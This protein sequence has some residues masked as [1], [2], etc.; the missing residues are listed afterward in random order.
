MGDS[1]DL[2]ITLCY[3]LGAL[4][5][6]L[7]A[8]TT[9][10]SLSKDGNVAF[11]TEEPLSKKKSSYLFKR[12]E[13]KSSTEKRTPDV[14][15]FVRGTA[16]SEAVSILG[17]EDKP[18]IGRNNES[19]QKTP[20]TPLIDLGYPFSLSQLVMNLIDCGLGLFRPD[21]SYPSLAVAINDMQ[22]LLQ[23]PSR[24][25]WNHYTTPHNHN[26][27]TNDVKLYGRSQEVLSLTNAF[28]RVSSAGR[29][30]SIF[31]GGFSG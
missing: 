10:Q 22:V 24:F 13:A 1:S 15:P 19:G 4:L 2:E 8:G 17:D 3:L 9:T 16:F 23:E 31:V 5:H 14:L 25:L 6:F 7:F 28:C 29:S 30:E 18:E 26:L 20:R 12:K 21:D 11:G 27:F